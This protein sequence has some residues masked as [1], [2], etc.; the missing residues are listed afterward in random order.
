MQRGG[1][2]MD[3]SQVP[4][5][6]SAIALAVRNLQAIAEAQMEV[7]QAIAEGQKQIA[8]MLQASGVGQ[9]ISTYG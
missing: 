7:M 6:T 3:I 9:N 4:A 2:D 1:P 5:S 8:A